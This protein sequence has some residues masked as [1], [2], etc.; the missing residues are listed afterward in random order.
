MSQR[1]AFYGGGGKNAPNAPDVPLHSSESLV[2]T[3]D[4]NNPLHAG[5]KRDAPLNTNSFTNGG[6][7][8]GF[9]SAHRQSTPQTRPG[10]SDP[11]SASMMRTGLSMVRP[12]TSDPYKASGGNHRLQ[13]HQA[14]RNTHAITT[15]PVTMQ[16][17]PTFSHNVPPV[18]P[19][20][21]I[22]HVATLS[23]EEEDPEVEYAP[24]TGRATMQDPMRLQ[25][26]TYAVSMTETEDD[27][28]ICQIPP[29][30]KRALA[31]I[32]MTSTTWSIV[33]DPKNEPRLLGRT[34]KDPILVLVT[35]IVT[36]A[37]ATA[38]ATTTQQQQEQ[39]QQPEPEIYYLGPVPVVRDPYEQSATPMNKL[40]G[41]LKAE[42][43]VLDEKSIEAHVTRYE[44]AAQ[45]WQGCTREE[46]LAGA[47]E[48]TEMYTK[49]FDFVKDHMTKKLALFTSCDEKLATHHKALRERD[50]QLTSTKEQLL[51]GGGEVLGG[52]GKV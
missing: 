51:E 7:S 25:R 33:R 27:S 40:I 19:H 12:G 49:V 3:P 8:S 16:P 20:P 18:T 37:A 47:N 52:Q 39:E 44:T 43:N 32:W 11:R 2:F 31:E 14:H 35:N 13:T 48:I 5:A 29:P 38:A 1:Q 41:L 36:A 24:E 34:G 30:N 28:E 4:P 42:N 46:W 10:T 9:S 15:T 6:R 17:L 26:A 45:R 23:Q 22:P 21:A 50:Q